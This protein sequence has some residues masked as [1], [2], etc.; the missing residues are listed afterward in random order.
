MVKTKGSGGHNRINWHPTKKT[1]E[2]ISISVKKNAKI[3][4][5]F[6]NK[7]RTFSKLTKERASVSAN[8]RWDKERKPFII[9]KGYVYQKSKIT[10]LNTRKG[11]LAKRCNIVWF[12]NTGEIIKKPFFLHHKDNNKLNDSFE[13]L[14]KVTIS[15]HNKIHK[16]K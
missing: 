15:S 3:N 10:E 11:R 14:Q 6:G 13:N 9:H 7:R 8:K 1:K 12:E 16:T 4:P 2:K 5:L